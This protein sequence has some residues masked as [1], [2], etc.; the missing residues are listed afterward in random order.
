[1]ADEDH[2]QVVHAAAE[3]EQPAKHLVVHRLQ[4]VLLQLEYGL[5]DRALVVLQHA[6]FHVQRLR[7]REPD[8]E[9]CA[10]HDRSAHVDV[11]PR[12]DTLHDDDGLLFA[13]VARDARRDGLEARLRTT[14]E[15]LRM[16]E[17]GDDAVGA[18]ADVEAVRR[19]AR[20]DLA[21]ARRAVFVREQIG[22]VAAEG[23]SCGIGFLQDLQDARADGD[24]RSDARVVVDVRDRRA[25]APRERLLQTLQLAQRRLGHGDRMRME[26]VRRRDPRERAG[27]VRDRV[28]HRERLFHEARGVSAD[29]LAISEQERLALEPRRLPVGRTKH[30]R[31]A[32]ALHVGP[33]HPL[34]LPGAHRAVA[35]VG[36]SARRRAA[37]EP[38]LRRHGVRPRRRADGRRHRASLLRC[39]RRSTSLARLDA[40]RSGGRRA[41]RAREGGNHG[42]SEVGR[43]SAHLSPRCRTGV[44]YL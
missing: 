11:A 22:P 38:R 37:R 10:L 13:E 4:L 29:R 42:S 5:R 20:V 14:A 18:V 31:R 40:R 21:D 2:A 41:Q 19:E 39:P 36:T 44:P 17:R 28:R 32:H 6:V 12:L 16:R 9:A 7:P 43:V 30:V 26:H 27:H 33:L 35:R 24:A 8:L 3:Q 34:H 1:M 15:R 23:Q 25:Q